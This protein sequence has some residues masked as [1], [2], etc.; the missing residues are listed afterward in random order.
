M[1][2]AWNKYESVNF[3][4]FILVNNITSQK[5]NN[6]EYLYIL[7]FESNNKNYGYNLTSGGE[8][9]NGYKHSEQIIN[10]MKKNRKGRPG[11]FKNHKHSPEVIEKIRKNA[12]ENNP[13]KNKGHTE[14]AKRK[15][16]EKIKEI[17]KN[18]FNKK[19]VSKET[20][21]LIKKLL[22]EGMTQT[23]I[24]YILGISQPIIS[25]IK[26]NKY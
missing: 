16:S 12:L 23:K 26:N 1:Q 14:E 7:L 15:I 11:Y 6:I 3:D 24:S 20:I 10:E 18:K 22:E 21:E 9:V 2:N 5:V 17:N 8:G 19:S 13:L 4:F 25:L